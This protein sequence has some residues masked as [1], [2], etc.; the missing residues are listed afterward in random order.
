MVAFH[1]VVWYGCD[2]LMEVILS[3]V[4]LTVGLPGSGKSTWAE[5]VRDGDPENVLVVERDQ[6]RT[7][8]FGAKYHEGKP[9]GKSE[10]KV[11]VVQQER[12]KNGI[13]DGKTVIVS[14]TH[15]NPKAAKTNVELVRSYGAE[16]EFKYFDI[17]VEECKRR[18]KIRGDKGGR[19]V[20]DFVIDKM[21]SKLYD[22]SGRMKE[23][24]VGSQN[25]VFLVPKTT[26]GSELLDKYNKKKEFENPFIDEAVVIV[27]VDGTLANNSADAERYLGSG[28]RDF[29]SF[30]KAIGNAEPN[31]S[32]VELVTNMRKKD[33]LG[34]IV[35][36][37]RSDQYAKE[38]L[39]FID[40]S[41]IPVS[42]VY[43]KRQGDNRKDYDYKKEILDKIEQDYSIVHAVDDR[44]SSIAV[45][46][47]RGVLVSRVDV[48]GNL[49]SFYGSGICLKCG[50]P[51][52]SGNI[53][54][55]CRLK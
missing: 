30:F 53:G 27:D 31:Q 44:E 52:K 43:A 14:D 8:L 33:G 50:K 5:E 18:N 26:Q 51:I 3:K 4:F 54:P 10:A 35:L 24:V 55:K 21:A 13:R 25:E 23:Y 28:K 42:R 45:F 7:E 1:C 6:I 49:N 15:S 47:R 34:I 19:R 17:P 32:V 16:P 37:G 9:D 36:T 29:K 12:I 41:G 11:T 38:L 40:R 39:S 46:E 20:P 22:D 48:E 2:I